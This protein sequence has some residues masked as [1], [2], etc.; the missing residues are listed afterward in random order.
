MADFLEPKVLITEEQI[1]DR[2]LEIA[3]ELN[4]RFKNEVPVFI[5]ILS[6]A[7][8]FF[9]DLIRA[10]K[11]DIVCDFIAVSSYK[12]FSST[13]QV[14]ILSDIET[15]LKDKRVV[16]VEDIIDSG[17]TMHF[18]QSVFLSR[19]AKD[20][21]TVTLLHKPEATKNSCQIDYKGFEVGDDFVVGYGMDFKNSYRNLPYIGV[22]PKIN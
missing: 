9:C 2:V 8:V 15:N 1:K 10:L 14:K 20:V 19:G 3:S 21:T 7:S 5:C 6:G 4:L 11:L 22:I 18:L 13:G 17:L 16:L 12:R